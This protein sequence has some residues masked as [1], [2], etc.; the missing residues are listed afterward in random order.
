MVYI[1]LKY[2]SAVGILSILCLFL[3]S[4]NTQARTYPAQQSWSYDG[5]WYPGLD[6]PSAIAT[7]QTPDGI[8]IVVLDGEHIKL[9]DKNGNQ[10]NS[11][12]VGPNLGK[13]DTSPDGVIFVL[14]NNSTITSYWMD[15]VER[16]QVTFTASSPQAIVVDSESRIFMATNEGGQNKLIRFSAEG[17]RE[18]DM[19]LAEFVY[20]MAID[21][22]QRLFV[23]FYSYMWIYNLD[24]SFIHD[25]PGIYNYGTKNGFAFTSDGGYFGAA[26]TQVQH[27]L[28]LPYSEGEYNPRRI[29]RRGS[30]YEDANDVAIDSEDTVYFLRHS[31]HRIEIMRRTYSGIL[32][33]EQKS[34]PVP[35]ILST[36]ML[37]GT[38]HMRIRYMVDDSDSE[39]VEVVAWVVQ[40]HN[41]MPNRGYW[42]HYSFPLQTAVPISTVVGDSSGVIGA[43]VP[44]NQEIIL[45]WNAEADVGAASGNYKIYM[46]AKDDRGLLN[47]HFLTIP[48]SGELPELTLSRSPVDSNW[49]Y[50]ALLWMYFNSPSD[51]AFSETGEIYPLAGD[52]AGQWLTYQTQEPG[53]P[54]TYSVILTTGIEYVIN[55]L[56][57]RRATNDEVLRAMEA[58]S[59]GNAAQIWAGLESSPPARPSHVNEWG[60]DVD[61]ANDYLNETGNREWL[62][63][64]VQE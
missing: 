26:W 58:D 47:L 56:G 33:P 31:P 27:M 62:F 45:D 57:Y 64:I 50:G 42:D 49:F 19:G 21:H 17:E 37:E 53:N 30:G 14:S 12:H 34:I 13:M 8:F 15:G 46:M 55:Q 39:T 4:V 61:S 1:H 20:S 29:L 52:F 44:A 6:N 23:A 48:A 9:L 40:E 18:W 3:I 43:N 63:W 54:G 35:H 16:G 36:S 41:V 28:G 10:T 2:I 32:D 51:Y 38:N 25:F 7:T 11:F 60:F 59:P 24:G 5:A 22:K